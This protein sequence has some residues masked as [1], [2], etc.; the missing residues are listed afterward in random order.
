M[1]LCNDCV[2]ECEHDYCD[3]CEKCHLCGVHASA[4]AAPPVHPGGVYPYRNPE[5]VIPRTIIA[6]PVY[7]ERDYYRYLRQ[8]TSQE[9]NTVQLH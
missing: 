9:Y 4:P 7:N 2:Q 1:S 8:S 5:W 3:G 6:P